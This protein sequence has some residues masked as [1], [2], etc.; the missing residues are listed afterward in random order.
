MQ[1]ACVWNSSSELVS[2]P[3]SKADF[4]YEHV[5]LWP[6]G[7]HGSDDGN[8]KTWHLYGVFSFRNAFL[9]QKPKGYV[10]SPSP[11]HSSRNHN[12]Y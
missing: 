10:L 11:F 8:R 2:Q 12:F 7:I 5:F 4:F 3:S 1:A 9:S 6:Q